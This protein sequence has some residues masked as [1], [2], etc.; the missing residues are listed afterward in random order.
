MHMKLAFHT[1]QL[2]TGLEGANFTGPD[3]FQFMDIDREDRFSFYQYGI[4]I[5]K[6]GNG[7]RA[8]IQNVRMWIEIEGKFNIKLIDY[9]TVH[10]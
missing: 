8:S 4:I 6:V 2:L 9:E 7:S 3:E 1:A 5:F 10:L